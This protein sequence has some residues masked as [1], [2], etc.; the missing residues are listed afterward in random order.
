MTISEAGSVSAATLAFH[1]ELLVF[2]GHSDLLMPITDGVQR[3]ADTVDRDML[4]HWQCTG[5]YSVPAF[6]AGSVSAQVCAIFI[7]EPYLARPLH[8]A[9]KM[10]GAFLREIR[11]NPQTL[12]QGRTAADITNAKAKAQT[13]LILALE[14]AEPLQ[15]DLSLLDAFYE[16]GVRF[17]GLTHSR[18]NLF[19][20]GT[21]QDIQVGGLTRLGFA[22]IERMQ[23]LGIVVDLAHLASP[24]FWDVIGVTQQPVVV[25][26]TAPATAVAGYRERFDAY[27][28]AHKVT[29]LEAIARTG[30]VVGVLFYSMPDLDAVARELEF[31]IDRVGDDYIS[32]GSDF[33]GRDASPATLNDVGDLP[34]LTQH[35]LERGYSRARIAKLMGG[36][37]LRVFAQVCG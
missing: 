5:Q 26:H 10:T 22:A 20:D 29:K 2:D 16:W 19:A 27:D 4:T 23:E 28:P 11:Q 34:Q 9:A 12:V 6:Q 7:D 1:R 8:Q 36:N 14:G 13:A 32:L 25:T 24:G 17:I 15:Q 3:L 35:L 21:Q 37:L 30:G 31:V 18:R 33:Y